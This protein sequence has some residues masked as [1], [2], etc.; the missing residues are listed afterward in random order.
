[1]Q[2]PHS[3]AFRIWMA[4][5]LFI[6]ALLIFAGT[7]IGFGQDD[8]DF[9]LYLLPPNIKAPDLSKLDI[10]KLKPSGKP[11]ITANDIAWYLRLE[12]TCVRSPFRHSKHSK[13]AAYCTRKCGFMANAYK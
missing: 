7:Q 3:G 4:T 5:Q 11:F 13:N 2:K 12:E 9:A 1:M 8:K 10:R 6:F